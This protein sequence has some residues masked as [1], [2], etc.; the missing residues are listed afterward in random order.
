MECAKR[1]CARPAVKG[2]NYCRAH[3]PRAGAKDRKSPVKKA[4]KKK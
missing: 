3:Q 1:D 2:S 4:A